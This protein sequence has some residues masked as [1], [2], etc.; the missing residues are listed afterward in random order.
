MAEPAGGRATATFAPPT[1]PLSRGTI[2]HRVR[3]RALLDAGGGRRSS[4]W[5]STPRRGQGSASGPPIRSSNR[6]G[7]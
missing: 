3:S 4:R 2:R 6:L 7:R 5:F 1:I